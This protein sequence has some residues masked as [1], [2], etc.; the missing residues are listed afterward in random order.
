[1]TL[2]RLD[3][4]DGSGDDHIFL[5]VSPDGFVEINAVPTRAE[6]LAVV[7]RF[8]FHESLRSGIPIR[9]TGRYLEMQGA[10]LIDFEQ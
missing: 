8:S 1:M 7:E 5:E 10:E 2:Y 9:Y 4:I 3:C 6:A